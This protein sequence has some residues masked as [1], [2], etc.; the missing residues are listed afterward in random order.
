M[1][2]E[3]DGFALAEGYDEATQTCC[4]LATYPKGSIGTITDSVLVVD[5]RRAVAQVE[6]AKPVSETTTETTATTTTNG[7]TVS[8]AAARASNATSTAAPTLT[9]FFGAVELDPE[10]Y[11]RDFNRVAAEVLQHLSADPSTRLQVRVEI[12]ATNPGFD[13]GRVRTVN[14]NAATL[15]FTSHGFEKD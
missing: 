9:R 12:T 6:A 11:A 8:A 2:W 10:R 5:P 13:S 7:T 14:E 1:L 15:K 3:L 4:G